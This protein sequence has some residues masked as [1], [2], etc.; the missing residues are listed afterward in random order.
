MTYFLK[1]LD[2]LWCAWSLNDEKIGLR[3]GLTECLMSAR[4]WLAQWVSG[5][6]Q[7]CIEVSSQ[8]HTRH[9]ILQS[10]FVR[11]LVAVGGHEGFCT[12]VWSLTLAWGYAT[13]LAVA[14]SVPSL[15]RRWLGLVGGPTI[16]IYCIICTLL[17][18]Q[19]WINSPNRF[20][21]MSSVVCWV[22]LSFHSGR[23]YSDVISSLITKATTC[24][25]MLS[26]FGMC[27]FPCFS[28]EFDMLFSAV[29]LNHMSYSF[30]YS[31][32]YY[33][34]LYQYVKIQMEPNK[35]YEVPALCLRDPYTLRK[36]PASP[37]GL[38]NCHRPVIYNE[39]SDICW[40]SCLMAFVGRQCLCRHPSIYQV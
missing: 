21:S 10:M 17:G 16:C 5:Q 40:M 29:S 34:A 19:R 28:L 1:A 23:R 13:P 38:L 30:I 3:Q 39:V 4:E 32:T 24:I 36:W 12:V 27:F 11:F 9:P 6:L 25:K 15:P 37:P 31:Y 35:H 2:L 26:D 8:L 22:P 7:P 33:Y 20:A 14:G 18:W